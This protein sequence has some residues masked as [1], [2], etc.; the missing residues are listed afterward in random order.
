MLVVAARANNGKLAERAA[1]KRRLQAAWGCYI[2]IYIYIYIHMHMCIYISIYI[3]ICRERERLGI[4]TLDPPTKPT[5]RRLGCLPKSAPRRYAAHARARACVCVC[6]C[7]CSCTAT[8]DR[9][10]STK[11]VCV[12][13]CVYCP[14]TGLRGGV[15]DL[16]GVSFAPPSAL[17]SILSSC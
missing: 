13:V 11:S 14:R 10:H 7:V 5:P 16:A 2:Y 3:Y 1:C 15:A 17:L 4:H 6:V 12:C 8:V 9:S